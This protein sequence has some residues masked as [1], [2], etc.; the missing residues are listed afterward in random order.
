MLHLGQASFSMPSTLLS[1]YHPHNDR[2]SPPQLRDFN[3]DWNAVKPRARILDDI[4]K[5]AN[6]SSQCSVTSPRLKMNGNSTHESVYPIDRCVVP[7]AVSSQA[8]TYP[9]PQS[10]SRQNSNGK[11]FY[12]AY[13]SARQNQSPPFKK[14]ST[15][16]HGES[17]RRRTSVENNTIATYLQ[18]PTSINDSKGSLPEFAAQVYSRLT[19]STKVTV[20]TTLR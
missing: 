1:T 8:P 16:D 4:P 15:T 6:H 3:W 11:P 5:S 10:H 12:Q 19:G 2:H 14:E 9:T 7:P 20:L 18:I 17:A 13:Y